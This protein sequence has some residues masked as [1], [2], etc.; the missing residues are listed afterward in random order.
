MAGTRHPEAGPR[1]MPG[2]LLRGHPWGPRLALGSTPPRGSPKKQV[3]HRRLK[4]QLGA[5]AGLVTLST[6]KFV[7][8]AVLKPYH[9]REVVLSLVLSLHQLDNRQ[10]EQSG[11]DSSYTSLSVE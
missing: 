3:P 8:T 9:L 11:A 1:L 4:R 10:F 7:V 2:N 6:T 5:Q